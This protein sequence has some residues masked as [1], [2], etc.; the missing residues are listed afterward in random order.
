MVEPQ[1]QKDYETGKFVDQINLK[2]SLNI[3]KSNLAIRGK[4]MSM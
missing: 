2:L 1:Y 3:V 4:I